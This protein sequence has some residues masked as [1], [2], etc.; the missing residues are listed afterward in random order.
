MDT[1]T[2]DLLSSIAWMGH[3]STL[4]LFI[5]A[6]SAFY[7]FR[8][9]FKLEG[10]LMGLSVASSITVA[11]IAIFTTS[12]ELVEL[13]DEFGEV[14]GYAMDSNFWSNIQYP[15]SLFCLF[16]ISVSVLVLASRLGATKKTQVQPADNNQINQGQG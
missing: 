13:T 9:G 6:V 16:L 5:F 1:E 10:I 15:F 2:T 12:G 8:A 7:L 4:A 14:Y 11:Q 3:F